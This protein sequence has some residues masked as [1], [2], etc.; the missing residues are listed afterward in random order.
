MA[1]ALE[2]ASWGNPTL[3]ECRQGASSEATPLLVSL[4]SPLFRLS[5]SATLSWW[6]SLLTRQLNHFLTYI[7]GW[8]QTHCKNR[9][10][11]L[12]NDRK[13]RLSF[14]SRSFSC[15]FQTS[16]LYGSSQVGRN[17]LISVSSIWLIR[18]FPNWYVNLSLRFVRTYSMIMIQYK[19]YFFSRSSTCC[20]TFPMD[21]FLQLGRN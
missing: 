7:Y 11:G 3:K 8:S 2:N 17:L 13:Y 19:L 9:N 12:H 14:L 16:L 15:C 18:C 10:L 1:P 5:G 21:A 4:L 6:E 20:Y